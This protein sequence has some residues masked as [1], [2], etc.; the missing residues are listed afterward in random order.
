LF[1]S[2]AGLAATVPGGGTPGWSA[3]DLAAAVPGGGRAFFVASL[4]R[5]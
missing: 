1:W 3:A 4:P 2:A 5:L